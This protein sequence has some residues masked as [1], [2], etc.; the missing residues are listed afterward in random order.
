MLHEKK[1]T[2][3]NYNYVTKHDCGQLRGN[4]QK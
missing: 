1:I 2:Y 3:M 4:V